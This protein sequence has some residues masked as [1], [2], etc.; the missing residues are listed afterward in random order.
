MRKAMSYLAACTLLSAVPAFAAT[1][2]VKG[3]VVKKH[4]VASRTVAGDTKP[5]ETTETPKSDATPAVKP[6]K[7]P[8]KHV[9]KP[10]VKSG[11]TKT[12]ETK[13]AE[14]KPESAPV[15]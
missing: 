14:T 10:A 1:P 8:N 7:K 15:K 5:A 9:R 12:G 6:E 13:P 11:E 3:A 4:H 2:A